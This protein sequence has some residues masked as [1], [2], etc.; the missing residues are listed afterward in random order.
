MLN[1]DGGVIWEPMPEVLRVKQRATGKCTES[2]TLRI[3]IGMPIFM[4]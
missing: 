4:G 3:K 2:A 1:I